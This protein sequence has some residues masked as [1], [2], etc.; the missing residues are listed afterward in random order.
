[1]LPCISRKCHDILKRIP[2]RY[3]TNSTNTDHQSVLSKQFLDTYASEGVL[4]GL[5]EIVFHRTYSRMRNNG[6]ME[7]WKD[8]LERV[9]N[10]TM[11]MQQRHIKDH[12]NGTWDYDRA[13]RTAEEMFKRMYDMK[14]LPSG[15]G[16]WGMGTTLTEERQLYA[17]L[18]SCAFVSTS[19]IED[20][21]SKPFCFCM[22]LSMLG[23]GVGFDTMGAD[24]IRIHDP[25]GRIDHRIHDSREG[26][27]RSLQV[28]LHSYLVEGN[29]AV[30]ME[31]DDI[32]RA[33][34]VL[35]CFGGVSAGYEP[36]QI[37]HQLVTELFDDHIGTYVSMEMIVN[38]M[39]II[40]KCVIAG[41]IRRSAEIA[42]GPNEDAFLD[43][44]N[45][46][47]NPS[48]AGYGWAS[49]NSIYATVGMDYKNVVSRILKN[50][51]PGLFWLQNAQGYSRMGEM[52]YKDCRVLGCN[53]CVE[54]SLESYEMCCLVET[55]PYNHESLGE[56]LETLE[57]AFLYAKTISTGDV[58]WKE[59]NDV[60]HRNRRVGISMSGIVQFIHSRGLDEFRHWCE[61]GY[62]HLKEYD[63]H[64]SSTFFKIPESIKITT[65]KP[66]GTLSLLAD[67]TPG[68]HFP[69]S[70]YYIRR[71]RFA[72]DSALIK[73]LQKAGYDIEDDLQTQNT[74]VVSFPMHIE[75]NV[76]TNEQIG[77]LQKMMLAYFLQKE[78]S[79][80]Q[81]SCT[82]D[83]DVE[84]EGPYL[85]DALSIFDVH[86][87]GISFL[88]RKDNVYDQMPIEPIDV[89][90]YTEMIFRIRPIDWT[91]FQEDGKGEQGCTSDVCSSV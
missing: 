27:V 75:G 31:Y 12:T 39:N 90:T 8:C 88:P 40:A 41:N 83:I 38:I 46:E 79:D 64:V 76:P 26:W 6:N 23:V 47:K 67:T 61:R 17:A 10:G 56:Y 1:M 66:S 53:P 81:V 30:D 78:W 28:L 19:T 22:D 59:S 63:A 13:E 84:E 37:M 16:L 70:E 4:H 36:L 89:K 3:H 74:V 65:I 24:T 69:E 85:A 82:V 55:F 73:I 15:R 35:K 20:D 62:A 21:V 2:K 44:K 80:N 50:G 60:L 7:S 11:G 87:K 33:G 48:R 43:L 9:V 34:S 51:E 25:Q 5:S 42:I 91:G 52:D 54:Q 18:N 72:K 58:H 71:L 32:R 45:Y 77:F 68:C 57:L 86:L 14:F 29:P 49:N